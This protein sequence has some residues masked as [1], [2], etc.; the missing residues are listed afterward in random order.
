VSEASRLVAEGVAILHELDA[1]VEREEK[2]R[3]M[4]SMALSSLRSDWYGHAMGKF[5]EAL[6][7]DKRERN[8]SGA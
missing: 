8:G 3:T 5:R 7:A 4:G 1:V 2:E 6:E